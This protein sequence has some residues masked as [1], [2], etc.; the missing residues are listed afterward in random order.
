M[1][2][3]MFSQSKYYVDNLAEN[4]KRGHR[5]KS[6]MAFGPWSLLSD[7]SMTGRRGR[8]SLIPYVPR[9]SAKPLNFTPREYTPSTD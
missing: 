8:Y 9:L 4:I 6:K 5:Q 2:S 3:I 1:L 7:I